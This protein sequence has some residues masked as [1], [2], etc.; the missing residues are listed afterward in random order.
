MDSWDSIKIEKRELYEVT[1]GKNDDG[2]L[3]FPG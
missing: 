1:V 3:N 2:L